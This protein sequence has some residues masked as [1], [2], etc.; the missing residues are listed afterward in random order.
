MSAHDREL[1]ERRKR[2]MEL[3]MELRKELMRPASPPVSKFHADLIGALIE[4]IEEEMDV[5]VILRGGKK[6]RK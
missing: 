2:I 3:L 5:G 6:K 1:E 4:E